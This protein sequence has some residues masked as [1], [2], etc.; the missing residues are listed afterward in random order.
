MRLVPL[1]RELTVGTRL[2]PQTSKGQTVYLL[3][4]ET[5][6]SCLQAVGRWVSAE[7]CLISSLSGVRGYSYS[8]LSIRWA[9]RRSAAGQVKGP[10]SSVAS[11][12]VSGDESGVSRQ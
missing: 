9:W 3:C 11:T 1:Q 7:S 6:A 8:F 4:I 10:P 12:G 5:M 2:V